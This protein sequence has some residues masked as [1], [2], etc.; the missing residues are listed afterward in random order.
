MSLIA[1]VNCIYISK[2]PF[3]RAT[4]G[5]NEHT[6]KRIENR[7]QAN[8][9]W[10]INDDTI[11]K[12]EA[13]LRLSSQLHLGFVGGVVLKLIINC[14]PWSWLQ[15]SQYYRVFAFKCDDDGND[16]GTFDWHWAGQC[17]AGCCLCRIMLRFI[18][19][20]ERSQWVLCSENV[21]K[22]TRN[23]WYSQA[24]L[25]NCVRPINWTFISRKLLHLNRTCIYIYIYILVCICVWHTSRIMPDGLICIFLVSAPKIVGAYLSDGRNTWMGR[26]ISSFGRASR[27]HFGTIISFRWLSRS[28]DSITLF[29]WTWIMGNKLN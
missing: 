19:F 26:S 24:R 17:V 9:Q 20:T 1:P 15:L 22:T 2:M 10:K 18:L 29:K 13:S 23:N 8:I 27:L 6:E 16:D 14:A 7:V 3:T 4:I 12:G 25:S 21:A 28:G 11:S 5:A